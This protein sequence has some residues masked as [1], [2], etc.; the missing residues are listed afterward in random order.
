MKLSIDF[1]LNQ[2]ETPPH[3]HRRLP[4][5]SENFG[6]G[7]L[8]IASAP[9]SPVA[10]CSDSPFPFRHRR[11][12]SIAVPHTSTPRIAHQRSASDPFPKELPMISRSPVNGLFSCPF[13]DCEKVF[14]RRYNL[15]SH[16][17]VHSGDRPFACPHCEVSFC[18]KH[19]LTR[20]IKSLHS[21]V[22]PYACHDCNLSFARSVT[23]SF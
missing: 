8:T 9:T 4:S 5:L 15:T 12:Y 16:L 20:H 21:Q 6:F 10:H 17:R 3:N 22:K 7:S 14:T 13:P 2:T 11:G 1:L 23:L 19:D 18:R